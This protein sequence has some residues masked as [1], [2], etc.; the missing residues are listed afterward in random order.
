MKNF[1]IE[2]KIKEI[3]QKS[4]MLSRP[5]KDEIQARFNNLIN[6][7]H[8]ANDT[9]NHPIDKKPDLFTK[10]ANKNRIQEVT[11]IIDFSIASN[12]STAVLKTDRIIMT[13]PYVPLEENTYQDIH[14]D[15]KD[16]NNN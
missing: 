14:S 7:D 3:K 12:P 4:E 16:A 13:D 10:F 1:N 9:S 15:M 11:K 2:A 6:K 5:N 8:S